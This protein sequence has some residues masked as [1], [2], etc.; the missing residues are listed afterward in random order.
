MKSPLKYRLI[1]SLVVILFSCQNLNLKT[2]VIDER[3]VGS[4]NGSEKDDQIKGVQVNWIQHRFRDGKLITYFKTKYSD[5][6]VI[7]S[8]EKGKWWIE[9]GLFYEKSEYAKK[10]DVYA[11]EITDRNHIIFKEKKLETTFENKSYMFVDTRVEENNT[12]K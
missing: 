8:I 11:F 9:N 5:G 6:Q 4:W 7:E 3:F 10:P 2:K 12:V 1:I